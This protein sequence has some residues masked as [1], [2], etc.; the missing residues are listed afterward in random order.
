MNFDNFYF[1]KGLFKELNSDGGFLAEF[2]KDDY[3][4]K[5]LLPYLIAGEAKRMQP[6]RM[7]F[8]SIPAS[9]FPDIKMKTYKMIAEAIFEKKCGDNEVMCY[10]GTVVIDRV[11]FESIDPQKIERNGEK[12]IIKMFDMVLQY[13][14]AITVA[15][16]E[17]E[18]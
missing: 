17:T 4:Y 8:I 12:I 9:L 11:C 3:G 16:D 5:R 6:I 7:E 15:C 18:D 1:T 10:A 14:T 2:T 13:K